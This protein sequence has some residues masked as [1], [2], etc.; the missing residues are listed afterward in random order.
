VNQL[1]PP[2]QA[3]IRKHRRQLDA[4]I[5]APGPHDFAVHA[6]AARLSAPPRPPHS[7]PRVVTIAIRPMCRLGTRRIDRKFCKYEREIFLCEGLDSPNRF[8]RKDEIRSSAHLDSGMIGGA[9]AL[10][11]RSNCPSGDSPSY[12]IGG[13]LVVARRDATTPLQLIGEAFGQIAGSAQRA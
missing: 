3:T 6:S 2:S 11:N 8:E 12:V 10:G 9:I 5:G 7:A 13:K 1:L 4:C